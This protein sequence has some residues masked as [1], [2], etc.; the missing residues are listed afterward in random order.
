VRRRLVTYLSSEAR[1][2]GMLR[3]KL[4]QVELWTRRRHLSQT[5]TQ[6]IRAYYAEVWLQYAGGRLGLCLF[7]RKHRDLGLPSQAISSISSALP[8]GQGPPA[9]VQLTG[10]AWVMC[11][12]G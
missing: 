12:V 7:G 4:E 8:R 11:R 3:G 2:A 1:K 6:R 9:A 10:L 5:L